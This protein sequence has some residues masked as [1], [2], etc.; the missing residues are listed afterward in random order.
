MITK[1]EM[2]CYDTDA[3]RL[4]GTA[5]KVV[6]PKTV[7]EVQNIIKTSN[8][9]IVPRGA[10]SGLLGGCVPDNSVVVDMNKMNKLIDF[11]KNKEIVYV[12]AGISVKELNE[13]L[14][15][16]GFEFPIQLIND[17]RTIGGLIAV[18]AFGSRS[19]KY[20]RIKNWIEKIEFVNGRGELIK[21]SKVD[22]G[23][24]CGMEGITGIIAR[25]ELKV[26][27]KIKRSIS[28]FQTDSLDEIL[29]I[30]RR[31]KLE[32]DVIMLEFF[33]EWVSKMIGLPERH[34]LIV[35]F[36]S[37][38]G[39][40]KGEQYK[41]ILDLRKK[42]YYVLAD[43]GYYEIE[44]FKFFFDKLKQIILY[45]ESNQIP[46]FSYLGAGIVYCFFKD[47][48]KE[49]KKEAVKLMRKIGGRF[50]TGIGLKRKE[51]VEDFEKKII[52]RVK[53]RYDPFGKLNKG[54][55]IN[56]KGSVISGRHLKPLQ[57]NEIEEIMP[58]IGEK[59]TSLEIKK[60]RT[61]EEK[62]NEF[63]EKAEL[64]DE[65]EKDDE[66]L[67]KNEEL[68]KDYGKEELLEDYKQTFESELEE[69]RRKKIEQFAKN[70][71]HDIVHP[72][73]E[74]TGEFKKYESRQKLAE[75][76][77]TIDTKEETQQK[78]DNSNAELK[79]KLTKEEQDK[80]N[81]VVFGG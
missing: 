25:A 68:L 73:K 66:G 7:E 58:V 47:D 12:E 75:S 36:N 30:S 38:R 4:V 52:Q 16:I 72:K 23:D 39:K 59:V 74:K 79:G 49:K 19:L 2:G 15:A 53:L 48:E 57:E 35:E 67:N 56:F 33:S 63:I 13:K 8:L 60:K 32:K 26:T 37:E 6:F 64:I 44:D 65:S 62:M 9:D 17:A 21:T 78:I 3:S 10:G 42:F 24:V 76:K 20:D 28:I 55:I 27:P 77:S 18:N 11:N 69:S 34:H 40:I 22:L 50:M 45:L 14:N 29:S 81:K 41:K 31:L 70:V 54:K 43:K 71:A 61:A 46:Y 51:F 1:K 5:R 80:I